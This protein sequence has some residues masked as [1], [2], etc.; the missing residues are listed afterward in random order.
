M[1]SQIWD[2][3]ILFLFIGINWNSIFLCLKTSFNQLQVLLQLNIQSVSSIILLF[4]LFILPNCNS[5]HANLILFHHFDSLSLV[6]KSVIP[7]STLSIWKSKDISEIMECDAITGDE[8]SLLK[9]IAKCEKLLKVSKALYIL[10]NTLS[11]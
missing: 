10:F 2:S 11:T 5:Y 9:E 1:L 7:E 8:F 4:I 3:M 6:L